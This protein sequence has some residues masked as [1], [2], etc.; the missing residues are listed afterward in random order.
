MGRWFKMTGNQIHLCFWRTES[1][2]HM[3]KIIYIELQSLQ[4]RRT[5]SAAQQTKAKFI[6]DMCNVFLSDASRI[7]QA[8]SIQVF[9]Q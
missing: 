3:L 6:Q 8:C 7:C 5:T 2:T 9:S 1:N 4:A